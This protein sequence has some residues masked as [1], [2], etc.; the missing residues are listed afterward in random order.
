V[1][2]I[3][4]HLLLNL[5]FSPFSPALLLL[6]CSQKEP[7]FGIFKG[8]GEDSPDNSLQQTTKCDLII[9]DNFIVDD[10]LIEWV[11]PAAFY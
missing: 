8:K 4:L 7:I 6:L 9:D 11:I 10:W 5:T 3:F 2:L 1:W